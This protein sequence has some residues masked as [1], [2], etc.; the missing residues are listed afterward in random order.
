MISA[1]LFVKSKEYFPI[2]INSGTDII[3]LDRRL[4]A[5]EADIFDIRIN[6]IH[7][8]MICG[9]F[10]DSKQKILNFGQT[11]IN[12][13]FQFRNILEYS[14]VRLI[15]Y[16]GLDN[17][18]FII[19]DAP[20]QID[21][22]MFLESLGFEFVK[23]KKKYVLELKSKGLDVFLQKLTEIGF[24]VLD[25]K[26]QIENVLKKIYPDSPAEVSNRSKRIIQKIKEMNPLEQIYWDLK[27]VH[28]INT[29]VSAGVLYPNKLIQNEFV[30]S[31]LKLVIASFENHLKEAYFEEI[32]A[33]L[34]GKT[35]FSIEYFNRVLQHLKKIA[36]NGV[37]HAIEK[38]AHLKEWIQKNLPIWEKAAEN[39]KQFEN[40]K[41]I[42]TKLAISDFGENLS[43]AYAQV[44][45]ALIDH[46]NGDLI[47]FGLDRKI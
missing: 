5:T 28:E 4:K 2:I 12:K 18:D 17:V 1:E 41:K 19:V 44:V 31:V 29:L 3:Q 30:E 25:K 23:Q 21:L 9:V 47:F 13:A 6:G 27:S 32:M 15:Q 14:M 38:K 42:E 22:V 39:K 36:P 37:K 43:P 8:G 16:F 34:E 40:K 20:E 45:K 7:Q 10:K 26:G 11:G 24:E 33:T 46:Y 35:N